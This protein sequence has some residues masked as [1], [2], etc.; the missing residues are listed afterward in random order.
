MRRTTGIW[1]GVAIW[2]ATG[3]GGGSS[4]GSKDLPRDRMTPQ[5]TEGLADAADAESVETP[6]E[7][8]LEAEADLAPQDIP[9]QPGGFGWPCVEPTECDSGFCVDSPQGKVCTVKCL[10]ECPNGWS[11]KSISIGSDLVFLCVPLYLYL[12]DP[13]AENKD[14]NGEF[15]G[16]EALCVYS[17]GQGRFCGGDCSTG[18]ACPPGYA[19][20]EA[21]DAGGVQR[22]QCVPESGECE[23]STR[24][25]QLGLSTECFVMNEFGTCKGTRKCVVTGLTACDA[26]TPAKEE[27]N[28]LDDDCDDLTDEVQ[29]QVPC[30]KKNEF[31]ECPG[32]GECVNGAIVG[33]DAKDPAPEVCNGMDDDCNGATDD[34]ICYDGNPCTQDG[35]DIG[36]GACVFTPIAGP[37]DDGN[38]CTLND[39]C[40][41]GQCAGGSPKVCDD[42]NPCTD[43]VCD[44]GTGECK[45][46]NNSKPCE[47]GNKC[48]INDYCENGACQSGKIKDCNDDNPCTLNEKCD[49]ATGNCVFTP[50]EGAPCDD[51]NVCTMGELCSGGKCLGGKDYC[52]A[53]HF[54]C[55]PGPGEHFCAASCF[56]IGFPFCVCG[57]I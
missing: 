13:C 24:A 51:Q 36:S 21:K 45:S 43:D 41:N 40:E 15:T 14:C 5:D 12:C 31:G 1:I 28:G 9:P 48:T 17:G 54:V 23:C 56:D 34:A 38:L 10:D 46:L 26:K 52:E 25:I 19:C 37:C 32:F 53:T 27:C 39:H 33:C 47:D 8:V 18:Q 20:R 16:G 4:P 7:G 49:P 42:G 55:T 3:C 57:C 2:V 50:N 22:L 11:C 44:S 6:A 35:C 30:S 29:G